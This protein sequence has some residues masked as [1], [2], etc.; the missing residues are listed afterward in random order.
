MLALRCAHI[1]LQEHHSWPVKWGKANTIINECHSPSQASCAV[2]NALHFTLENTVYPV[3]GLHHHCKCC[4]ASINQAHYAVDS[5]I[6]AAP[7]GSKQTNLSARADMCAILQQVVLEHCKAPA[8]CA[9]TSANAQA[10]HSHTC[11]NSL[12]PSFSLSE[13][14]TSD[15]YVVVTFQIFGFAA[16]SGSL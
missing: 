7:C 6:S 4:L 9:P 13:A 14:D 1:V 12:A 15:S 3:G 8:R 2:L 16:S 10:S 11:A 5:I